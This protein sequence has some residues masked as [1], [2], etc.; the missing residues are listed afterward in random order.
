MNKELLHC[1]KVENQTCSDRIVLR[2]RGSD[3]RPDEVALNTPKY[4]HGADFVI[5]PSARHDRVEGIAAY[6]ARLS[7]PEMLQTDH[8]VSP[9]LKAAGVVHGKVRAPSKEKR[10]RVLASI[11]PRVAESHNRRAFQTKPVIEISGDV[12]LEAEIVKFLTQDVELQILEPRS[13][14]PCL[15]IHR[16]KRRRSSRLTRRTRGIERRD[17]ILCRRCER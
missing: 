4:R 11:G 10:L 6:R 17:R 7:E 12:R 8:H 9:R 3:A 14:L 5:H 2:H 1:L 16:N 13:D 15:A